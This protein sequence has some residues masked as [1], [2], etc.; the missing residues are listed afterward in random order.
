MARKPEFDYNNNFELANKDDPFMQ[1][2]LND[3]LVLEWA[4]HLTERFCC[5]RGEKKRKNHQDFQ[6]FRSMEVDHCLS[7]KHWKISKILQKNKF[8]AGKIHSY[9][10]SIKL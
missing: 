2:K 10:F 9:S 7:R 5:S 8:T 1:S 4:Q 6:L 3:L